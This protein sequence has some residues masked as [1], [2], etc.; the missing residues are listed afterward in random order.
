[1]NFSLP[2]IISDGVGTAHDL[3]KQ[4]ENGFMF[5]KGNTEELLNYMKKL[6]NDK[7]LREKMGKESLKIVSKW[8]FDEDVKAILKVL[9]YIE[10]RDIR[11]D[12]K[13]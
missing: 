5:S 10:K 13:R 3:M 12:F 11:M 1:M 4:E 6:A 2:I 7:K 8:N 9:N